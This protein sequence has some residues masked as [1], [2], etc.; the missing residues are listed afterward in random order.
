[1]WRLLQPD[2]SHDTR[3]DISHSLLRLSKI[4]CIQQHLWRN[5]LFKVWEQ[6]S[7][8]LANIPVLGV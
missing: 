8:R 1:M 7:F 2:A 5:S 4:T 6:I 3:V